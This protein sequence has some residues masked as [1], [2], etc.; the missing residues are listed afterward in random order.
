MPPKGSQTE[1]G[2]KG[3]QKPPRESKSADLSER[4]KRKLARDLQRQARNDQSPSKSA[5]IFKKVTVDWPLT[6]LTIIGEEISPGDWLTTVT[7]RSPH[8]TPDDSPG[9][10]LFAYCSDLFARALNGDL[11]DDDERQRELELFCD[12]V[13][14]A[15]QSIS[16]SQL[17]PY[18]ALHLNS[19]SSLITLRAAQEQCLKDVTHERDCLDAK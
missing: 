8:A 11:A 15:N 7:P 17:I 4:Q 3:D 6:N 19:L 10:A 2:K 1:K 5:Q 13:A 14:D 16:K 9:D 12:S 18:C